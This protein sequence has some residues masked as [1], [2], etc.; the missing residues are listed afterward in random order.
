MG[1]APHATREDLIG[2]DGD[3]GFLSAPH[4]A[5][6][7]SWDL[8]EC[9]RVLERASE[10]V[11]EIT[12]RP[13]YEVDAATGNATD[14]TV[15]AALRAATCAVVEQWL[16]VGEENDVDGLAGDTISVPGFSGHRAPAVSRR[17]LRLLRPAGLLAQPGVLR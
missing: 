8:D 1:F 14:E 6:A 16:E 13:F 9:E 3:R 15:A 4:A 7:A 17:V 2:V 11:D 10:L 5:I 12:G